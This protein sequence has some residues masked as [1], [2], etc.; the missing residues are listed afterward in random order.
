[1]IYYKKKIVNETTFRLNSVLICG[2]AQ[3]G[4]NFTKK[5]NMLDHLRMHSGYKPF[6]CAVCT[7]GFKQK[8]QLYKHRVIH[9]KPKT[10]RKDFINIRKNPS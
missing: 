4:K 7:K 6:K 1:M 10:F 9:S 3:C 8:A 2:Y 5:C